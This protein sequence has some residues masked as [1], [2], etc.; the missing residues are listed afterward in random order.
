VPLIRF[1]Y[2]GEEWRICPQHL[3]TLIHSPA[4][5]A[6]LLPGAEALGA[7]EHHD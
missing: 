1:D 4:R 6:G 3:P 5:L 2:R 7:S